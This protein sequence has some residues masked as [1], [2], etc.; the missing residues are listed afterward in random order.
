MHN[1]INLIVY[2]LIFVS[3]MYRVVPKNGYHVLFLG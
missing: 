2:V 3:D 1:V